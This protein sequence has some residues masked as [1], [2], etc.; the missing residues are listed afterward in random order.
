MQGG[1]FR[2]M[3]PELLNPQKFGF[4]DSR[5]TRHSDCYALGMVVY[6]VISG[7]VPFYQDAD[8]VV[9]GQVVEG[10]RP[11][12]PRGAGG[13]LFTDDVWGVLER[14][15]TPQPDSRPSIEDVL[16]CLEKASKSW[17]PPPP[18]MVTG[19]L[20]TDLLTP[21]SSE[22]NTEGSTDKD[23]NFPPS[24][25]D[26]SQ[27]SPELQPEG[28]PDGNNVYPSTDKFPAL[29]HREIYREDPGRYVKGS[30]GPDLDIVGIQVFMTVSGID[31]TSD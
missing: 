21:S 25:E 28:D 18:W 19:A 20:T 4:K 26:W 7:R 2:W 29:L 5:P 24:Q 22:S 10:K 12:R 16:Q 13:S 9:V 17:M 27:S 6:E 8:L 31:L 1:T 23:E 30:K 15:W 14:C 3:G 11:G